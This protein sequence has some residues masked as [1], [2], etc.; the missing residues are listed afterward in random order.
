M[1]DAHVRPYGSYQA[2]TRQYPGAPQPCKAPLCDTAP[3]S[4]GIGRPRPL[5]QLAGGATCGPPLFGRTF[6]FQV[7]AICLHLR[8]S[9]TP[10]KNMSSAIAR[11]RAA[12]GRAA[13]IDLVPRTCCCAGAGRAICPT[14]SP[15]M[16]YMS[17][18]TTTPGGGPILVVFRPSAPFCGAG[19]PFA[20]AFARPL[21]SDCPGWASDSCTAVVDAVPGRSIFVRDKLGPPPPRLNSPDSFQVLTQLLFISCRQSKTPGVSEALTRALVRCEISLRNVLAAIG[22][23]KMQGGFNNVIPGAAAIADVLRANESVR[24]G[25]GWA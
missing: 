25:Q 19:A 7:T 9:L 5:S 10:A 22:E 6:T 1:G 21:I 16:L 13:S 20:S 2:G 18:G 17:L 24:D 4:P 3:V 8:R 14:C 23:N 12:C 11:R 15:W